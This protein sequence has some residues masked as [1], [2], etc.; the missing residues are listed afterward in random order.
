MVILILIALSMMLETSR[1]FQ[2]SILQRMLPQARHIV[3]VKTAGDGLEGTVT[4]KKAKHG[5]SP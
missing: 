2:A 4:L 3:G 5:L 1:G